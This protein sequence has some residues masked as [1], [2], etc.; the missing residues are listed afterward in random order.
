VA[1]CGYVRAQPRSTSLKIFSS[2]LF[3]FSRIISLQFFRVLKIKC[4]VFPS[5]VP[6]L[7]NT[8]YF[9]NGWYICIFPAARPMSKMQIHRN[10]F[11]VDRSQLLLILRTVDL[12]GTIKLCSSSSQ[13]SSVCKKNC[14]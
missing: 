1:N 2:S 3:P 13:S 11:P 8:F 4:V 12:A 10:I 7:N 9:L 6:T 5:L 14:S